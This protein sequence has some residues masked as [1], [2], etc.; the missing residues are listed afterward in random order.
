M[1]K[2]IDVYNFTAEYSTTDSPDWINRAHRM[3]HRVSGNVEV[4]YF[5]ADENNSLKG[6]YD[7]GLIPDGDFT[8]IVVGIDPPNDPVALSNFSEWM[9]WIV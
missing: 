5:Y 9:K 4:Q 1:T 3:T 8:H 2:R 7:L 6:L